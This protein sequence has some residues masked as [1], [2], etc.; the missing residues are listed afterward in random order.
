M[1]RLLFENDLRVGEMML[2]RKVEDVFGN[3]DLDHFKNIFI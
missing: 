1:G 3:F 2:W